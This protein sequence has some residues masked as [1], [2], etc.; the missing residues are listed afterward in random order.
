MRIPIPKYLTLWLFAS[1]LSI[2]NV[3]GQCDIDVQYAIQKKSDNAY[4]I[5]LKSTS[6]RTADV[7]KVQLYDL[8]TGK[9]FQQ[10]EIAS[11]SVTSQEVFQNVPPS[12][13]SI[14]IR[15]EHCEKPT[16]L[17]GIYGISIGIP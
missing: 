2:D 17:G 3:L 1:F 8:I 9:I 10:K 16:T 4:S 7:I 13:Y 12:R 5:S 6:T 14:I 11:I 15:F